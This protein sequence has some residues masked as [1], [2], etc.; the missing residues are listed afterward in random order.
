M[1]EFD[2]RHS[3]ALI[4]YARVAAYEGDAAGVDSITARFLSLHPEAGRNM[5]MS[6]VRALGMEDPAAI[7]ELAERLESADE[8]R[9]RC[10][11]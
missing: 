2:P 6:A 7:E 3:T 10:G 1:L 4:H 5:E 8:L 11:G 9:L